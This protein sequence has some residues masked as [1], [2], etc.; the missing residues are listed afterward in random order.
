MRP[1]AR[2]GRHAPPAVDASILSRVGAHVVL[3]KAPAAASTPVPRR[4]VLRKDAVVLWMT[5]GSPAR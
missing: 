5:P 2:R 1:T 4:L 3:E